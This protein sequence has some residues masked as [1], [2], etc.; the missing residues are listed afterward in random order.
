MTDLH[1]AAAAWSFLVRS[2]EVVKEFEGQKEIPQCSFWNF[3][4]L[5]GD[6]IPVFL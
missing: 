4:L 5:P 6:D 1:D 3:Q 2:V